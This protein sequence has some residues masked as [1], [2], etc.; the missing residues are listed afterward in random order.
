MFINSKSLDTSCVSN[1]H[2]LPFIYAFADAIKDKGE[3]LV[4]TQPSRFKFSKIKQLKSNLKVFTPFLPIPIG[5]A[6]KIFLLLKLCRF[7]LRRQFKKM[8]FNN[9]K[10]LWATHPFHLYCLGLADENVVV[11][12]CYDDFVVFGKLK[13]D[14]QTKQVEIKLAEK[15][16]FILATAEKLVEKLKSINPQT[17]YFSNAVDFDLFNQAH[18]DLPEDIKN[19]PTPRIGFTGNIFHHCCDIDLFYELICRKPEWSFVFIG[20]IGKDKKKEYKKFKALPNAFFLGWKDYYSLPIY[21]KG[22]DAAILPYKTNEIM[23]SVNPNK[24]YQF[25]AAGIPIASTPIPEA[26]RFNGLVEIGDGVEG[27]E[28]AIKRALAKKSVKEIDQLVAA[29]LDNSWK[30]RVNMVLDLIL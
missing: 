17:Y 22:L 27:F 15:C 11:Y 20:E 7:Y 26:V 23:E 13:Q 18:K 30:K 3:I 12:E 10:I 6:C 9:K 5:F 16:D 25:M 19:I 1:V 14:N 2:R 21:L 24:I 29:G 28:K 4:V 8:E